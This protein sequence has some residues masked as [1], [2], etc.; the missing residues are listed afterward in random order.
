MA[1]IMLAASSVIFVPR[2]GGNDL[3]LTI[4]VQDDEVKVDYMVEGGPYQRN[5]TA[6]ALEVSRI[7]QGPI[8]VLINDGLEFRVKVSLQRIADHFNNE[9]TLLGSNLTATVI[10]TDDLPMVFSDYQATLVVGPGADLPDYYSYPSRLWVERGGLWIGIGSGSAPFMYSL[11][12]TS[13]PNATIRLDFVEAEYND[14]EGVSATPMATALGLRY[15]A[16]EYLFRLSDLE[17]AGGTSI[18][19]EF[20]RGDKLAT[21]GMVSIG[22]GTLLVLAGDMAPP[23]LATGEEVLAWD[24]MKILLLNVPWWSGNMMFETNSTM[25]SELQ[26]SFAMPLS[27][28]D[29]ICCGLMSN[30]DTFSGFRVERIPTR[31]T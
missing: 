10:G 14:G 18:G 24:L 21:A 4:T 28:S 29:Y 26:G 16:P 2:A 30:T 20:D 12:N 25:D 5:V 23:P 17:A 8:Y 6:I 27:G 9:L 11:D 3:G 15:V 13:S 1:V 22:D 7:H 31:S 19:Y